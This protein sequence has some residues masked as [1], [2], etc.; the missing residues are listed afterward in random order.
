MQNQR[1]SVLGVFSPF[2]EGF[3]YVIPLYQLQTSL[4]CADNGKVF[5]RFA[6]V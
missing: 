3:H 1:V 6:N 4:I 5:V 2:M